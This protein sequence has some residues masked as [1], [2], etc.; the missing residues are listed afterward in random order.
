MQ[1]RDYL[2]E[3]GDKSY[4]VI[5]ARELRDSKSVLDVGCG[6]NS[7]LRKVLKTFRSVGLDIHQPNIVKSK[8]EKIHDDYLLSDVASISLRVQPKSFDTVIALDLIEHL[9]KQ[10]GKQL[11]RDLEKIAK[12]KVVIMTP[13]GFYRQDPYAGNPHQIHRSGWKIEDFTGLG[14]RVHGLRGLK[15]LRGEYATIRFKPWLIWGALS[16]LSQPLVYSLPNLAYQIL[17]VKNL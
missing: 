2:L 15:W 7:P 5:L 4:Y 17:A 16:V 10:E 13:N 3:I 11:L 12:K 9:P 8:K 14:Y 6:D 1:I